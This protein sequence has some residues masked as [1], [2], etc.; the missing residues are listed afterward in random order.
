MKLNRRK[1]D[2]KEKDV[3]LDR[4]ENDVKQDHKEKDGYPEET[5]RS[6]RCS[7]GC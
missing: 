2:H 3:M 6:G 1:L 5:G 4:K 7:V